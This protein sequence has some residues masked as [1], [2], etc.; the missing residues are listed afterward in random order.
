MLY[1]GVL[2]I[3]TYARFPTLLYFGR[4]VADVMLQGEDIEP[5]WPLLVPPL[6]TLV[7]DYEPP[8]KLR[9]IL[10][11]DCMLE[12]VDARLLKRTGLDVLL[13]NVCN[14]RHSVHSLC[15]SLK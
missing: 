8:F 14:D 11:V 1:V 2:S 15:Y 13:L 9:G 5:L 12:R 7:D 4:E 10:A 3:W 6:M